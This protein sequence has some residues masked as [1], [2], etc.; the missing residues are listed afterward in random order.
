MGELINTSRS[1]IRKAVE[2]RNSGY[3]KEVALRQVEAGAQYLDINCGTMVRDEEA[4]MAWLVEKV[5][6]V[7]DVPLCI[8][9]P[10]PKALAV[11][12]GMAAKGQPMINSITAEKKRVNEVL[13]LVRDY[14][15]KVVALCI[16]DG[17]MPKNSSDRVNIAGTLVELLKAEGI[18]GG[19]IYIDPLIKPLSTN[20]MAGWEVI[21]AVRLMRDQYPDVHFICGLS[22]ISFGLP[23]RKALNATFMVQA[24]VAGMDAFVLDPTDREMMGLYYTGR[25]LL[26]KDRYCRNYL[27]AYR[28]GIFERK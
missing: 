27:S 17:G 3:I 26:G 22:N 12:L 13:P 15:A 9:S 5:Q 6:E 2:E 19:D 10:N 16:D 20:D 18:P 23:Q 4:V 11:G 24:M 28:K 25:A 8:D 7:C 1:P 21:E 14:R